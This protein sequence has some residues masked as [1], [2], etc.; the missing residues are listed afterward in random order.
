MTLLVRLNIKNIN[1]TTSKS[2]LHTLGVISLSGVHDVN[3]ER[4]S[5][6]HN[7]I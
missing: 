4:D 7:M 5:S 6:D 1:N 3:L 2:T